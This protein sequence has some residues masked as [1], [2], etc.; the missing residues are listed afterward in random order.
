MKKKTAW[1]IISAALTGIILYLVKQSN[2]TADNQQRDLKHKKYR[3]N[4][5]ARAKIY[6]NGV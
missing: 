2:V 6:T 1:I 4:F 5:F 3:P